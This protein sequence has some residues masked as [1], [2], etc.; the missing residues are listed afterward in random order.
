MNLTLSKSKVMLVLLA[1]VPFFNQLVNM[2]P[3]LSYVQYVPYI[4]MVAAFLLDRAPIDM[5]RE[6]K[7]ILFLLVGVYT[8]S[9]I[10]GQTIYKYD[11]IKNLVYI[12]LFMIFILSLSTAVSYI[13]YENYKTVLKTILLGN[14]IL[15]IM[16]LLTN[17]N[18]INIDNYSWIL[19]G[20]RNSRANFGFSHPNTAGMFLFLE[21]I[22][23]YYVN[24]LGCGRWYVWTVLIGLL[25]P[26][27]LATG[28]RTAVIGTI[29]FFLLSLYSSVLSKANP[30]IQLAV[31]FGVIVPGFIVMLYQFNLEA[32]FNEA[33]GR[34]SNLV[35][36]LNIL[37]EHD[38]V[39][40]GIAPVNVSD[41]KTMIDGL[42][43]SDNWYVTHLIQFGL[44]GMALFVF[45]LFMVLFVSIR[46]KRL[47]IVTL[48]IILLFYSGAENVM[49]I[50]G[51]LI[52]WVM[53]I[54]IFTKLK[55]KGI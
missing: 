5:S 27:L 14:S 45:S 12:L 4:L 11:P 22:L 50:P 48:L 8:I 55:I 29:L 24:K 30:L 49:F 3:G 7:V 28:S 1:C 46:Q 47:G 43:F 9:P 13:K 38:A 42:T 40:F 52:S 17:M 39:V 35:H 32:F 31:F 51:V 18:E 15:L 21:I 6:G 53:W 34:N 26:F 37:K 33:S 10:I 19:A 2:I 36:N 16:N 54:L 41:L 23:I 44:V 20:E 25:L